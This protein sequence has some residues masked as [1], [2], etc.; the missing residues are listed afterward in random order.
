MVSIP[1]GGMC[2]WAQGP[3]SKG[4]FLRPLCQGYHWGSPLGFIRMRSLGPK[5]L[6]SSDA[7]VIPRALIIPMTPSPTHLRSPPSTPRL[8]AGSVLSLEVVLPLQACVSMSPPGSCGPSRCTRVDSEPLTH[9]WREKWSADLR[10][11]RPS[12]TAWLLQKKKKM[13]PLC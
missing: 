2:G 13:L 10:R 12:G 5:M 8:P 3:P 11:R 1:A 6:L 9:T 7:P 4:D